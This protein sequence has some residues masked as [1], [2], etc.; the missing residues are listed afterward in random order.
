MPRLDAL[1][2]PHYVSQPAPVNAS[3][4]ATNEASLAGEVRIALGAMQDD[5]HSTHRLRPSPSTV[6]RFTALMQHVGNFGLSLASLSVAS[7][8]NIKEI[9]D[10][11]A[12]ATA[13]NVTLATA[14]LATLSSL[15]DLTVAIGKYCTPSTTTADIK[16]TAWLTSAGALLGSKHLERYGAKYQTTLLGA[17]MMVF[18]NQ[19]GRIAGEHHA[20]A[21]L[22]NRVGPTPSAAP[23]EA[24]PGDTLDIDSLQSCMGFSAAAYRAFGGIATEGLIEWMTAMEARRSLDLVEH[25][26][27][28]E[29]PFGQ[30]GR[31]RSDT[32]EFEQATQRAGAPDPDPPSSHARAALP[33]RATNV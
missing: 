8:N 33:D 29:S 22:S 4:T 18:F 5:A 3:A 27:N 13:H 11:S 14:S 2:T 24:P 19:A 9:Y 12:L 20:M 6:G 28:Y 26:L 17:S 31:Y 25:Q 16:N 32:S 1:P 15:M 30:E 23:S 7:L 10:D 21:E